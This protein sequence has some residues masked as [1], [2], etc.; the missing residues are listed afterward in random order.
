MV[1]EPRS[2]AII[3]TAPE[4][5]DEPDA[6]LMSHD[7]KAPVE[8]ELL[9]VK[10]KPLTAKWHTI[11]KHLK[12]RAGRL[13][14]F[15]GLHIFLAYNIIF[16]LLSSV[17]MRVFPKTLVFRSFIHI[18]V[19]VGLCRISLLWTHI[20]ISEPSKE[21]WYKR[22][23][24]RDV[25]KKVFVP[26]A[27]Y[28]CAEQASILIPTMLAKS[29]G[30]RG[31][32]RDPNY[33]LTRMSEGEQS[34][35]LI[36]LAFIGFVGF[37]C[38]VSVF[39]PSQIAF[40]RVQASLLSSEDESI[41]PFDR[42]FGGKIVPVVISGYGKEAMSEAWKTFDWNSRVRVFKIYAKVA[43]V[44]IALFVLYAFVVLFEFRFAMG[45]DKFDKKVL[46]LVQS[47]NN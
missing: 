11:I 36:K 34:W 42:T 38:F 44:Q 35:A 18:L 25:G 21:S 45:S 7:E 27:V 40:T 3:R 13:S 41:V 19:S 16:H 47:A 14:R 43:I 17:F 24:S 20:V 31:V 29:L 28:A 2:T 32:F 30:L 10:S 9:I 33:V 6:P 26:T 5:S 4:D 8:H 23:V 1:E 12:Q 22:I 39:L 37:A 15:R 46:D